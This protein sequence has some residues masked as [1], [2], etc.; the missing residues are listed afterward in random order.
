MCGG[1]GQHAAIKLMSLSP[2]NTSWV[3]D[4]LIDKVTKAWI[5]QYQPGTTLPQWRESLKEI[6]GLHDSAMRMHWPPFLS[7]LASTKSGR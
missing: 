5:V 1:H 6:D 3:D 4:I 7:N 2:L